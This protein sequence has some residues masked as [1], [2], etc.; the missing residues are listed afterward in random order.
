MVAVLIF[1]FFGCVAG[2]VK[3]VAS[4]IGNK[5]V[6]APYFS[7]AAFGVGLLFFVIAD[8]MIISQ[9]N[10]YA[11]DPKFEIQI[12]PSVSVDGRAFYRS[13][14]NGLSQYKWFSG[15]NPTESKWVISI[16]RGDVCIP[17]EVAR[18]SKESN[19]Y[20]VAYKAKD[21]TLPLGFS[22]LN[23]KYNEI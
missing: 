5:S 12:K 15:S 14:L 3:G 19:L 21:V 7:A 10:K 9:L 13:I 1:G 11:I 23:G 6:K 16:S 2:I 18:D 4:K 22:T 17:I 8:N 20:W